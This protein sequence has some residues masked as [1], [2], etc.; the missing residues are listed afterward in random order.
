MDANTRARLREA[1]QFLV[2][3]ATAQSERHGHCPVEVSKSA[4]RRSRPHTFFVTLRLDE[5][6]DPPPLTPA[7]QLALSV[8]LNDEAVIPQVLADY[9]LDHG[10]EYAVAVAAKGAADG[11]AGERRRCVEAVRFATRL[12]RE[13]IE[14]APGEQLTWSSQGVI[15]LF[16]WARG[17]IEEPPQAGG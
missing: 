1:V 8:L 6:P 16:E 2:Q 10:H 17:E 9:L 5:L 14:N 3:A 11:R 4:T 12:V 13:F 15:D 7:Q